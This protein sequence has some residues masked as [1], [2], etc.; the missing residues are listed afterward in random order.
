MMEN[1]NPVLMQGDCLELLETIPDNSIDM[2]CCDMPYGTTNCRWDATLDLRRLW[3]QY[4]RV[5]TE[6]AA[7]VLFAQTPFDKVLGVSN[8]EWLRYELI[9]QKTHATGHLN[10]K[11]MPMKAHENILVFYNKLPTYNPQKTTGHI[12]KTSVKRRDNTS[13]YGEQN[14]VQLSYEST[15][16]HPRS[17]LTFPKDTQRIALHPTQKPLALIEWLVS[18][19]TN[20]GDAV[21]D[22]C[23]GSGTTGEACQRLG[24]RFV[25]MELD[26]KHFAVAS[27]RILSGGVPALRNAA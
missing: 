25:G 23:M 11:K 24:R 3:A 16:R 7:I 10:A 26:E 1:N 8:L 6:N 17:V 19:F 21:L 14:F 2:V 5:T 13:V 27:S 22:N 12:R 18:T 9:W 4:R 20:E 15:D